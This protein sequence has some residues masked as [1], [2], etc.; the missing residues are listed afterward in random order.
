MQLESG[1]DF[2]RGAR[3]SCSVCQVSYGDNND[4]DCTDFLLGGGGVG[5]FVVFFVTGSVIST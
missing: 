2:G 4:D 1:Q 3:N 5:I